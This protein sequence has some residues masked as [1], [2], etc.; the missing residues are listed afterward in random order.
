M[1][2]VLRRRNP[3]RVTIIRATDDYVLGVRYTDEIAEAERMEDG[4]L[5]A[6][7]DELKSVG[8]FWLDADRFC[9]VIR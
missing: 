3:M 4:E 8:R 7:E 5:Y 2:K 6:M 1:F 9:Q